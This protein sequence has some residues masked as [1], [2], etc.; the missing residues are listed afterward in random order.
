MVSNNLHHNAPFVS[1][2]HCKGLFSPAIYWRGSLASPLAARVLSFP[3]KQESSIQYRVSSIDNP[4]STP[5]SSFLI[6][7]WIF[8]IRFFPPSSALAPLHLSRELY[9][10]TI[11]LQNEPK[12][13]NAKMNVTPLLTKEYGIFMLCGSRKNEP[14]RTQNEPN[15]GPKLASFSP[16]L[17]SFYKEIFAFAKKLNLCV[18]MV[19]LTGS[20][21]GIIV[22]GLGIGRGKEKNP[23]TERE[24][25]QRFVMKTQCPNCKARFNTSET[26]VGKQ[27]KC[28]KCA[29]PFIIKPFIETPAAGKPT[30]AEKPPATS[31][32]PV[33]P[34]VQKSG[35]TEAASKIA[36]PAT[37]T[38][39]PPKSP[40]PVES[41]AAKTTGLLKTLAEIKGLA[42]GEK[43]LPKTVFVYC[44][45]AVRI[46]AG[47]LGGLA[48]FLAI[49]RQAHSTLFVTFAAADVFLLCSV[50][51]EL[52]LFYKMWAAIADEQ[53]SI[54]PAKAVAFLFVPVFNIYW[55]L[56][57]LTG[58]V[59]DYNALIY[60][61]SIKAKDLSFVLLLI[62]AF[63][64]ILAAMVV[65][66]PMV[67]V[68]AFIRLISRAFIVYP[69]A[70]WALFFLAFAAGVA[71]F[72]TYILVAIK[73]CN[74][75]NSLPGI[76]SG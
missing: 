47:I 37:P 54:T 45:M 31:P 68:F 8:D 40:E 42:R 75:I 23:D 34:K 1:P 19:I 48:L 6:P 74:A 56:C 22:S 71:H 5:T 24:E 7:C 38:A 21:Y 29:K 53:A 12:L 2:L 36:A 44:W 60:R 70:S 62:Y 55:T 61:R 69:E 14:K 73:T 15:F 11:F 66:I 28:P 57:M 64:F 27:A 17:A 26:S 52:M 72:I 41:K 49:K 76:K 35:P 16:K 4:S 67:C 20:K 13:Q 58:F 65:V 39:P 63:T 33:E 30:A 50:L 9:K 32:K 59:E 43:G 18:P 51:V 25:N 10:S 46:I 3:R